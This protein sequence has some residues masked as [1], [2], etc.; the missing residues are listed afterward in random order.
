[1]DITLN[2]LKTR[3]NRNRINKIKNFGFVICD[4]FNFYNFN[5]LDMIDACICK[6]FK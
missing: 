5:N 1:M 4:Q 2:H 3:W 6:N